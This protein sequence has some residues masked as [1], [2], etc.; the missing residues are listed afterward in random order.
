MFM[1][2]GKGRSWISRKGNE[3]NVKLKLNFYLSRM[4]IRH[5]IITM[6]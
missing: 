6:V 1:T 3:G 5:E 2:R 4:Y